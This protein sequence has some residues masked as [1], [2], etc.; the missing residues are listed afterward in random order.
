MKRFAVALGFGAAILL[1]AAAHADAQ[2][3]Y[4]D[5]KGVTKTTQY[6]LDIPET[7]RDAAVWVGPTGIGKPGLSEEQKQTKQR[8]DAYRRIREANDKLRAYGGSSLDTRPPDA[9]SRRPSGR[10]TEP[11]EKLRKDAPVMCIAGERR[12]MTAPG[13]WEIQGECYSGPSSR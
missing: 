8:E 11:K 5:D 10:G 9:H 13:H 12:V 3:K 7:Y 4:T 2:Y 6:K 1:A